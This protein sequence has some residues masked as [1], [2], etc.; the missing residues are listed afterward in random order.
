MKPP[1]KNIDELNDLKILI[2]RAAL[3]FNSAR[4]DVNYHK[5]KLEYN[6]KYMV[7]ENDDTVYFVKNVRNGVIRNVSF[8]VNDIYFDLPYITGMLGVLF[9][10]PNIDKG[11]DNVEGEIADFLNDYAEEFGIT[12]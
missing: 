9:S 7:F 5:D 2:E 12:E 1:Y 6:T 10:N 8:V 3:I 4:G 11:I